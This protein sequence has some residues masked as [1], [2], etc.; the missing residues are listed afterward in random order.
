VPSLERI[1]YPPEIEVGHVHPVEL[2]V[3]AHPRPFVRG[4]SEDDSV[5]VPRAPSLQLQDPG[6]G[7]RRAHPFAP[8]L[9]AY[10]TV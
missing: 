5:N 6:D 10:P 7:S 8:H 3:A 9:Y 4:A 1:I 2:N